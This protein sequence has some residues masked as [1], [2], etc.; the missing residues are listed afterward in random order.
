MTKQWCE[1]SI[2]DSGSAQALRSCRIVYLTIVAD[3]LQFLGGTGG[4]SFAQTVV[5]QTSESLSMQVNTGEGLIIHSLLSRIGSRDSPTP[6]VVNG[7]GIL[8][9]L[10][11]QN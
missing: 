6:S 3:G 5:L 4:A 10:R 9:P 7:L 1:D 8:L 2:S 11:P